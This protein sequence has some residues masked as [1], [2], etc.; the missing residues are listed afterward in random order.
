M[1]NETF[2]V[3]IVGGGLVGLT[4]AKGLEALN[5]SY[6]LL[7]DGLA[8]STLSKNPRAL[9]LSKTSLAILSH[10]GLHSKI[11]KNASPIKK[12]HVSCENEFGM[13]LLEQPEHDFLGMV[14]NLGELQ[15][16]IYDSIENKECLLKGKFSEYCSETKKLKVMMNGEIKFFEPKIIIA[17]D[18]ANSSVRKA[19]QL[20]VELGVEQT[21]ILS[22]LQLAEPHHGLA[23]ERFTKKGPMA[24]LP[25][26][27]KEM[28]LVWAM[29]SQDALEVKQLSTFDLITLINA[30]LGGRIGDIEGIEPIKTYPLYQVFMPK[31]S[32]K[33][34]L[35]L[36]N[37]AHTLHPVAGQGFNLSLRDV[38]VFLDILEKF[39]VGPHIFPM[40]LDKRQ[41]DQR[42][43]QAI[44][45]FL[46]SGMQRFD[47][48]LPGVR[49]VSLGLLDTIPSFKDIVAFYAQGFGY[50]LPNWVYK[51]MDVMYE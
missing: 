34:I 35:F 44:T 27:E 22:L 6:R 13:T 28:A 21:G 37:A 45:R 39:G 19:T 16:T 41:K 31:Q 30:Q 17:A 25:W 32:Y 48:A 8:T 33:N 26:A 38:A 42:L 51:E 12:I 40:Y 49:G 7:D 24:L 47:R 15:E 5:V 18:G 4:L 14:I 1:I 29:S 10:F 50:P 20:P 9:A 46:A 3:L 23:F 11:L 36:G 2:D 43:T